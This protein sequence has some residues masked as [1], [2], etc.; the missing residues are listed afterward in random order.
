MQFAQGVQQP[1]YTSSKCQLVLVTCYDPA[2]RH[3]VTV[4][5]KFFL[6]NDPAVYRE[7]LLHRAASERFS[8]GIV[9]FITEYVVQ[10]RPGFLMEAC[11]QETLLRMAELCEAKQTL[12]TED[13]MLVLMLNM[14]TTVYHLH[15]IHIAHKAINAQNWLLTSDGE[16]KLTDFGSAEL[17]SEANE[18]QEAQET[19]PS[20]PV[21]SFQLDLQGIGNTLC[22]ITMLG[23]E[24]E[25]A[26]T[27]DWSK[28]PAIQRDPSIRERFKKKRYSPQ[29]ANWVIDLLGAKSSLEDLITAAQV[30]VERGSQ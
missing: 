8:K 7:M 17:I 26:D 24:E 1:I 27:I 14:L 25:S 11:K 28:K 15:Q 19:L 10:G 6:T 3:E 16:L 18:D 29:F 9:R 20:L 4:V 23:V 13:E 12:W 5:H 21:N 2:V 22:Q 30:A